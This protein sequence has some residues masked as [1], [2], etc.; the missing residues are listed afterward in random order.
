MKKIIITLVAAAFAA[1]PVFGQ[2]A[3]ATAADASSIEWYL[4]V[5]NVN[6]NPEIPT[7]QS[8][9][10]FI[11]GEDFVDWGDVLRYVDALEK[12]SDRVSVER[13]GTTYEHRPFIQMRITSKANQ[14]RLEEIRAQQLKLTDASVSQSLDLDKM[15]LI[16]S[17]MG[18][19]HGNEASGVNGLLNAAYYFTA[20]EDE[21]VKNLLDN[22]VILITPALN[23]DGMNRFATWIRTNASENIILDANSREQHEISPSSRSNHYWYD[24][25]RDWLNVQHDVGRNGVGVYLKWMPNVV[26]DLHEMSGSAKSGFYYF[27]PGDPDRTHKYIPQRNQDLTKAISRATAAAFDSMGVAYFT[28]RGYD[29]YYL[30]KGAAY[31]DVQG[32]VC[33]LHEQTTTHGHIRDSRRGVQTFAQ[34]VRNQSVAAVTLTYRSLELKDSLQQYM[35]DFY[36]SA[37]EVAKNDPHKAYVFDASGDKGR[38][39]LFLDILRHHNI[40]VYNSADGSGKYVVPLDQ[41]HYYKIKGMF[42]DIT[43]FRDT[44]FYDIST[45]TLPRAFNLDYK[46]VDKAPALGPAIDAPQFPAGGVKGEE[47][48]FGYIFQT[49]E[50][51]SPAVIAALQKQGIKLGVLKTPFT[52]KNKNLDVS[53]TFPVGTVVVPCNGQKFTPSELREAVNAAAEKYG[54]E[55]YSLLPGSKLKDFDAKAVN[56]SPVRDASTALV[57]ASSPYQPLGEIWYLLDHHYGMKHSIVE[58]SR[59]TNK[60]FNLDAYNSIILT[61]PAPGLSDS[62][63]EFFQ[64]L[65][66]WVN[67]GG[68]LILTGKAYTYPSRMG[69]SKLHATKN[70][71]KHVDGVILAAEFSDPKSPLL[72]GYA[73]KNMAIFKRSDGL[74][75][76]PEEA[77][78]VVS[79]TSNPYLSGW[80]PESSLKTYGGTPVV[81][82]IPQGNGHI[83]YIAEDL[84]FRSVWTGTSHILTN[85]IFFGD[86]LK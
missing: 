37:A 25:N 69:L 12:A 9:L 60:D 30:G 7:P 20:S 84:N 21:N 24:C 71:N 13:T 74:I 62:N 16:V 34:T 17:L 39:Y 44:I 4:P 72:W 27:S 77:S 15:P 45:W 6:F 80:V 82:T 31:G 67:K 52:Y 40:D 70:A 54:I 32:S 5:K 68:T 42:E 46:L 85:A 76:L 38:E 8:V 53:R 10:G 1:A 26:L 48:P 83:V 56:Y 11:P 3:T 23:P 64:R 65:K 55:A 22:T 35:R 14:D 73:E 36:L 75:T 28:E 57:L 2:T 78:P 66:A 86:K 18:T 41:K 61:S 29:D 33:L 51:Y 49:T 79:Y 43:S 63:R 81:A 58:Y 19:I 47:S 50:Y 59:L